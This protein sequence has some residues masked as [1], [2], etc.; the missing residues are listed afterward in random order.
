MTIIRGTEREEQLDRK[1]TFRLS[2]NLAEC[3][4]QNSDSPQEVNSLPDD[5][6]AD[7]FNDFELKESP[8][9][10]NESI[11]FGECLGSDEV[12]TLEHQ[13]SIKNL[14]VENNQLNKAQRTS[15]VSEHDLQQV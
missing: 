15:I 1:L 2:E 3:G 10:R 6:Q 9:A 8:R 13:V 12:A 14:A 11:F 4:S 7:Q 5:D